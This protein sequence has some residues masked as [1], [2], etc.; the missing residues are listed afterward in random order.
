[1][2]DDN[3][4]RLGRLEARLRLLED[5]RDL[6]ELLSRYSFTADVHRGQSWVDLWTDDGVYDLGVRAPGEEPTRY[7][8]SARLMGLITGPGMPPEGHSQHHTQGPLVIRVDGDRAVAEGYSITLVHRPE[9]I[10]VWNMGFS[11]W[12]FRREGGR[13]KIVRRDRREV[14]TPDQAGV[15]TDGEPDATAAAG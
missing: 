13:W 6:R 7:E 3:D 9:G 8:G 10:E 1:M 15:I 2:G 12:S 4:E 14:G 5:E 11:R